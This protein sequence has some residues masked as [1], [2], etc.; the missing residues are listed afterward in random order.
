MKE[1]HEGFVSSASHK[2]KTISQSA[3][4]FFEFPFCDVLWALGVWVVLYVYQLGLT[5]PQSIVLCILTSYRLLGIIKTAVLMPMWMGEILQ[6]LTLLW[7]C[8]RS[9]QNKVAGPLVVPGASYVVGRWAR[10]R[11]KGTP[12]NGFG[13]S[14]RGTG[15]ETTWMVSMWLPP[16]GKRDR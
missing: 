14:C 11:Q 3:S 7:I 1:N 5:A 2:Y 15:H 8:C 13:T 6:G 12:C 16:A 4:E 10:G 9:P